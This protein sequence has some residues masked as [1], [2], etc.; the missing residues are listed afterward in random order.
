MAKQTEVSLKEPIKIKHRLADSQTIPSPNG[1]FSKDL[2]SLCLEIKSVE[3]KMMSLANRENK[4]FNSFQ[5]LLA[6]LLLS[7]STNN[8]LIEMYPV[9]KRKI[10]PTHKISS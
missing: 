5:K 1:Q 9:K 8:F 10:S 2:K 6:T 7:M 3:L 4:L